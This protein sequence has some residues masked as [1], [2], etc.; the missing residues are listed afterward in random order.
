MKKVAAGAAGFDRKL[1]LGRCIAAAAAGLCV[2]GPVWA[3]DAV[4]DMVLAEA[5]AES[6]VR[7]EVN[8][9]AVPRLESHESG[10]QAPR[11]DVSLL[12]ASRSGLGVAVGLTS[13]SPRTGIQ[14]LGFN[15]GR[16][17]MDLGV[18]YRQ[19]V[20]SKQVDLTAW[21][22]VT[23][24]QDAYSLI[25]QRQPLYG[26]RVEMKLDS[27]KSAFSSERGFVGLQL[28]SGAKISIKRKDGRPM[29][30]YRTTF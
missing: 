26:A 19:V 7:I 9:S 12:P 5:R 25:Q 18:H 16:T 21:R 23:G 1:P 24:D 3:Q 11:V 29:V 15:A 20:Y 6:P 10:F 17:S 2:L 4:K 27:R 14:P 30:Y 28:E 13:L 22:R 8:T